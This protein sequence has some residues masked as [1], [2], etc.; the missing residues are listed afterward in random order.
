MHK[1]LVRIANG[2]DLQKQS[3]LSLFYLTR[4]FWQATSVQNFRTSTIFINFEKKSPCK[5]YGEMHKLEKNVR[6]IVLKLVEQKQNAR[7]TE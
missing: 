3:E 7:K 2:Q 5:D 6:K 1:M 4:P